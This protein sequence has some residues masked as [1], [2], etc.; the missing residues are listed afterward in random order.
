MGKKLGLLEEEEKG[1]LPPAPFIDPS[2][3]TLI[4]IWLEYHFLAL[5]WALRSASWKT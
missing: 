3:L 5:H 4:P 1:T 2:P